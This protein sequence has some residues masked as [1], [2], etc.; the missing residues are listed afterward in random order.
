[1][2][3]S[4]PATRQ[5]DQLG[6]PYQTFRHPGPVHSLE[7][8]AQERQQ[9]PDQVIRSIVFRIGEGDFVMVLMAGDIQVSWRAL[10]RYLG[11]SRLTMASEPELLQYTSYV[12][13]S[14]SPFG[15]P[16]PM[17]VLIDAPVLAN[18]VVSIGSGERGL[19]VIMTAADLR[20]ALPEAEIGEF[21]NRPSA[22]GTGEAN[23]R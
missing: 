11:Q 2:T 22:D 8:A 18:E 14:V 16:A 9:Q 4:T 5:L 6:I 23:D 21:G 15:L 3:D 20:R 10:R 12:P 1:M 7:Q 19:T 13:G 17:R